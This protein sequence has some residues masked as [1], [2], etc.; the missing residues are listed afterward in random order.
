MIMFS[1]VDKLNDFFCFILNKGFLMFF[2]AFGNDLHDLM[3]SSHDENK[4]YDF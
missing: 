2:I 1:N 4:L 3:I